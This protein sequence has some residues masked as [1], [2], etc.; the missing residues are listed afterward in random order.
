MSAIRVIE[1]GPFATV[2]D[3]GRRRSAHLGVPRGGAADRLS[4]R[5]ANRLLGNDVNAAAIECAG[6]GG[7]FRFETKVRVVLAGADAPEALLSANGTTEPLPPLRQTPVDA[8]CVVRI[9]S[10]ACGAFSILAIA[11][12]LQT[13]SVLGSR[14]M[15]VGS[16]IACASRPLGLGDRLELDAGEPDGHVADE[17]TEHDHNAVNDMLARSTLRVCPGFHA[18]QFSHDAWRTLT[19][20]RF[21]IDARSDRVGTRLTEPRIESPETPPVDPEGVVPGAIQVPSSGAAIVLGPDA[22]T[23][24]GYPVIATVIEADL[25]A[26]A[27]RRPGEQ[28]AFA[29]VKRRAAVEQLRDLERRIA[30]IPRVLR[31]DRS[32]DRP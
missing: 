10:F 31:Q 17:L 27:Q 15:H 19:T 26:L 3:L 5:I 29:V 30:A 18:H 25:P 12:G 7:T 1:P 20:R 6:A 24:G 28:I 21:T 2:Q 16:G 22:P 13:P 4:L 9:G 32:G 8:G 11:G 23:T 14:S